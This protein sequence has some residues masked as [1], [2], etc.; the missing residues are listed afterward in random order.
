LQRALLQRAS[1][2]RTLMQKAYILSVL[3]ALHT[4]SLFFQ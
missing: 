2:L 4:Q 3:R 1:T